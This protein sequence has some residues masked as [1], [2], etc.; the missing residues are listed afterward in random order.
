MKDK[1]RWDPY[2]LMRG[3]YATSFASTHFT[4]GANRK[5]LYILGVGFDYRMTTGIFTLKN[6][7]HGLDLDCLLI[8]YD[9]GKSS[10]SRKY[11]ALV[12]ANL[13]TLKAA[14]ATDKI[15]VKNI[16][17]WTASGKKK[18]RVGDKNAA[19][20]F[21]TAAIFSSYTDV[22]VDISSL[23]R[24]IYFS[25]IGKVQALFDKHYS[26][27]D[28]NLFVITLENAQL[29]S[30]IK[31]FEPDSELSYVFGFLGGSDLTSDEKQVIW[32]P[33]L[34]EGSSGQ[35]KAAHEMVKPDEI[36][37]VVPFPSQDPRRS[38]A[39]LTEYHQLLFD[40]LNIEGQNIIYVPEQN[41]FE[42]YRTLS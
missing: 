8:Q 12:D 20:V 10:S 36:C 38:D 35:I 16:E 13:A 32:L 28:K 22:F 11:K 3:K 37:P 24:G 40:E 2:V 17:L 21:D 31:E 15:Q 1:L 18:R 27:S 34:G 6:A 39:L 19:D 42:V 23:P 4:A 41:P 30:Q 33:I 14:L 9:E 29:D 5:A 7:C 26:D 25:L